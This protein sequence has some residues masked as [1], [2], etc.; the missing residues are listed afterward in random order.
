MIEFICEP[1]RHCLLVPDAVGALE[2]QIHIGPCHVVSD[3]TM[4]RARESENGRY[5]AFLT[6]NGEVEASSSSKH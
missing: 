6:A 5:G 2:S 4:A 3:R 1:F